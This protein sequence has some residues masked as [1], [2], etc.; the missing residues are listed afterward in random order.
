VFLVVWIISCI[1]I[2]LYLIDDFNNSNK[3]F[4]GS[5]A[6]YL[7]P[8][9][10]LDLLILLSSFCNLLIGIIIL[11]NLIVKKWPF[12]NCYYGKRYE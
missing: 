1:I 9:Y 6:T 4:A 2:L 10:L 5:F 11:I 7:T 8:E 12:L 3:S